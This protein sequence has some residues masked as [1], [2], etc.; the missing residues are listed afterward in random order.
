MDILQ[1]YIAHQLPQ[2]AVQLLYVG[3]RVAGVVGLISQVS[4]QLLYQVVY[5]YDAHHAAVFVHDHRHGVAGLFHV[6]KQQVGLY[7]LR[8][9]IGRMYG[10]VHNAPAGPVAQAEVVLGVEDAD[11][12][13]RRTVT[14]GVES[15]AAL[16]DGLFP[17]LVAVLQPEDNHVGAVGG[18]VAHHN[19]VKLK[20][21]L[22]ELFLLVVYGALLAARVYHHPYLFLADL[23]LR[24]VGVYAAQAKHQIGGY[25]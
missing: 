12:L 13:V 25:A 21:V 4:N 17:D 3:L 1:R 15:V 8:H 22:D 7:S 16:V 9:K 24:L 10:L 23:V 14:D 5:G 20:D 2:P 19:V 18:D 11:Y 6:A